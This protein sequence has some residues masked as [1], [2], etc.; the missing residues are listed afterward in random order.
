MPGEEIAAEE[1][2][3]ESKLTCKE[4]GE[5]IAAEESQPNEPGEETVAEEPE[6]KEP[7]KSQ[8]KR[9]QPQRPSLI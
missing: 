9:S 8:E 7:I 2:T 4:P 1:L 6:P 5:E 3:S